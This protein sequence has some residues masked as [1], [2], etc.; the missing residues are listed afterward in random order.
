MH[1]TNLSPVADGTKMGV[2]KFPI[3]WSTCFFAMASKGSCNQLSLL[4][5][6]HKMMAMNGYY[7]KCLMW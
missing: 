2:S 1:P 3:N 5:D 7:L 6:V 4:S